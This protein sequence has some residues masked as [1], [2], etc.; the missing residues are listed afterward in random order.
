M[1]LEDRGTVVKINLANALAVTL[2]AVLGIIALKYTAA[3][4]PSQG[5][6]DLVGGI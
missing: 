4:V 2:M 3:F 6:R 1:Q 5:Y